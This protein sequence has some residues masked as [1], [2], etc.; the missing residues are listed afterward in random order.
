MNVLKP[1]VAAAPVILADGLTRRFGEFVAVDHIR[2]RCWK[3]S[4]CK[5]A[6]TA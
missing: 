1:G 2:V 3:I 4:S 6:C 5:P